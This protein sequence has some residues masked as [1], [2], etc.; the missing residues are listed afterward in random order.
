MIILRVISQKALKQSKYLYQHFV[1]FIKVFLD[2]CAGY[3]LLTSSLR[4]A[5]WYHLFSLCLCKSEAFSVIISE[6]IRIHFLYL[7]RSC[8]MP[9]TLGSPTVIQTTL[10]NALIVIFISYS[11]DLRVM[12]LRR[13]PRIDAPGLHPHWNLRELNQK[14]L[15]PGKDP[16]NVKL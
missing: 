13:I 10:V 12:I 2:M 9:F 3:K 8:S 5:H 4:A 15:V 1:S 14:V 11:L 6:D 16:E 7:I